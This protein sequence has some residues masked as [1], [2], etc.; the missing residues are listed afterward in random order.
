MSGL[1]GFSDL[2]KAKPGWKPY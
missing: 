2:G 1:P